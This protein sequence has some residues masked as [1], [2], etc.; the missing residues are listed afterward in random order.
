MRDAFGGVFTMKLLIIFLVIYV[1]FIA[2]AL[3]YAK[4]FRAKNI[5]VDYIERYEGYTDTSKSIIN[6]NLSNMNYFVSSRGAN[7]S[8]AQRVDTT[9]DNLGYCI[10]SYDDASGSNFIVTTFIEINILGLSFTIPI[11]GEVRIARHNL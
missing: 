8:Y 9:C 5:I 3:N 7:S 11:N 1:C 2:I 4:A 6:S 10:E